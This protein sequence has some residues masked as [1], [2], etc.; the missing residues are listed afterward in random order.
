L[1]AAR[2]SNAGA[3]VVRPRRS[4]QAATAGSRTDY[5]QE[6]NVSLQYVNSATQLCIT[7]TGQSNTL[8]PATHLPHGWG[9]S[10]IYVRSVA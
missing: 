4:T 8:V 1:L 3:R 6:M 2:A 9:Q 7:T 5:L 10:S